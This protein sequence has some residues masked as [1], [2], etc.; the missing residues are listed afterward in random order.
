MS[1]GKMIKEQ[2]KNCGLSQEKVA[3]L[4]GVSRQAVTKW[5]ADQ[6]APSTE[7]LFKL[8]EIFGTTVDMLIASDEGAS[9]SSAEQV[10]YL[11]KMEEIKKAKERKTRRKNNIRMALIVAAGYLAIFLTCRVICGG[12]G[13]SSIIGWLF[14]T[15]PKQSS[16]LFGW[17]ISSNMYLLASIISIVPALFGKFKFSL[18]TLFAFLLGLI[19]GELLGPNPAGNRYGIGH[20]GWLIWGGIFAFSMVIGVILEKILKPNVSLKSKKTWIA[21]IVAIVCAALVLVIVYSAIPKYPQ[22][23]YPVN[24][25]EELTST[26][27]NETEYAF[28][29]EELLPDM[30]GSFA[31]QLKNRFSNKIIG[32]RIGF[33]SEGRSLFNLSCTLVS[34]L[35]EN[36]STIQGNT[37]YNGVELT[38]SDSHISFEVNACRYDIHYADASMVTSEQ[39]MSIAQ[40]IINEAL[41]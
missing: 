6:T 23:E 2:R 35:S 7:N 30:Q 20:Y 27:S 29:Q 1:L 34:A 5:E 3:E 8:A 21:S 16:Y 26:F 19:L 40:S 28:P 9:P 4:V 37:E 17:L 14:G 12:M 22:P 33:I 39:A 10:Y 25:Y 13:Q 24:T 18:S 38:V 41:S 15:D 36:Q 11:Y 32:Y 31:V